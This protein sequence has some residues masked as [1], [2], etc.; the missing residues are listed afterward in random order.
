MFRDLQHAIWYRLCTDSY[1]GRVKGSHLVLRQ[2][3][4]HLEGVLTLPIQLQLQARRD[5]GLGEV[6]PY[7]LLVLPGEFKARPPYCAANV[8]SPTNNIFL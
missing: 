3:S 5:E 2:V 6:Y 1:Y 7:H 8:Q 4:L